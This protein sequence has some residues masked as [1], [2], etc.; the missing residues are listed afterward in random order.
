M[1]LSILNY[2]KKK[3]R[4]AIDKYLIKREKIY[5]GILKIFLIK[6][7]LNYLKVKRNR[8]TKKVIYTCITDNYDFLKIPGYIHEDWDYICFTD[9]PNIKNYGIWEIRN[10]QFKDLDN[11]R[12]NRWHKIHPH[13]CLKE[14]EKSVYI[15]GNIRIKSK[16]FYDLIEEYS[17]NIFVSAKHPIRDCIYDEAEKCLELKLEKKYVIEEQIAIIKDDKFPSNY[18]LYEA[19][20]IYRKHNKEKLIEMEKMW[21]FFVKGM[22]KRDQ[23]SLTYCCW[24]FGLV[25]KTFDNL[26]FRKRNPY[27]IITPHLKVRRVYESKR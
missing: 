15:D 19:N 3:I 20:I 25:Y 27:L 2:Y 11:S 22:A 21:W 17:D 12:N 18:G 26:N 9:N 8:K 16:E 13:I 5:N 6:D 7:R 10:L 4:E 1:K 14:Y 23:L 24:K